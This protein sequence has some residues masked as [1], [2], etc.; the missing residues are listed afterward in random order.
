MGGAERFRASA[1]GRVTDPTLE[2]LLQRLHDVDSQQAVRILVRARDELN[3]LKARAVAT[4]LVWVLHELASAILRGDEQAIEADGG[5]AYWARARRRIPLGRSDAARMF[6]AS[7]TLT[8][9]AIAGAPG[10]DVSM[11]LGQR[12][13]A[14]GFV[15][16]CALWLGPAGPEYGLCPELDD[17]AKARMVALVQ[18]VARRQT[19]RRVDADAYAVALLVGAGVE[20]DRAHTILKPAREGDISAELEH[21]QRI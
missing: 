15:D 5:P 2:A 9:Q 10:V 18:D 12:K 1:A 7:V 4:P 21:L 14:T 17:D 6:V 16:L 20:R 3:D 19:D 13:G 8:L 11:V